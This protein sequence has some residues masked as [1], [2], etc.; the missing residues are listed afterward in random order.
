[1]ESADQPIPDLRELTWEERTL[2]QHMLEAAGDKGRPYLD[3]LKQ[4]YVITRCPC[5][6]PSVD[7]AVRGM[8]IPSGPMRALADFVFQDASGISGITV[9][10]QNGILG[11]L[12]VCA[13]SGG[14]PMELPAPDELITYDN[15]KATEL[16]NL[17]MPPDEDL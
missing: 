8:E 6:C 5:G 13:M 9:F 1:M 10:E 11:V 14:T 2:L 7:L 15:P 17:H 4:A 16:M 3:Q 12:E